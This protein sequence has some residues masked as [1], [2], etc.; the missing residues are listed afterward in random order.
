MAWNGAKR[1]SKLKIS[2]GKAVKPTPI[3]FLIVTMQFP[4]SCCAVCCWFLGVA[5]SSPFVVLGT[6]VVAQIIIMCHKSH[7]RAWF[8]LKLY[9]YTIDS[10]MFIEISSAHRKCSSKNFAKASN[11][12]VVSYAT[13]TELFRI[14]IFL[15]MRLTCRMLS[16]QCA[17][18]HYV[19]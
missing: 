1:T 14:F 8:Y 13:A 18:L 4:S 19:H 6:L 12:I 9:E 5:G 10:E 16:A 11:Y 17:L 3:S 7:A 15:Y 2:S